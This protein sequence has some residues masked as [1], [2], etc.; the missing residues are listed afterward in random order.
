MNDDKRFWREYKRT[1]KNLGQRKKRRKEKE[2]V[3]K[4]NYEDLDVGYDEPSEDLNGFDNQ[5]Q[6][7]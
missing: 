5:S 1:I 7:I 3:K 4:G 2:M 6:G